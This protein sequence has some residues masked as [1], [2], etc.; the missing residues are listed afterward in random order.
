MLHQH[1]PHCQQHFSWDCG[2]AC[3][4]MVVKATGAHACDYQT[5]RDMCP[6]TSIWTVDLAHLLRRFGLEVCFFTITLGP[7]P[8]YANEGFYMENMQEDERRVSQ[9]FLEAPAAGISVQQRSLSSDELQEAMLT[10]A[11][12]VIALVDK[13]K[14]LDPYTEACMVLPALCGIDAGYTGHYIL[15]IGFDSEPGQFVVRDPAAM[16]SELRVSAAALDQARRSFGTDEDL[17]IIPCRDSS[18]SEEEQGT[19]HLAE[20]LLSS[21][22][23]AVKPRL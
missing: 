15:I 3:V 21:I 16:V 22:E 9:L 4:L 14:L 5:L 13:R 6:T 12:L 18:D 8:A 20:S 10:G 19:L 7:N 23:A 17:I 1:V 11:C 2:L